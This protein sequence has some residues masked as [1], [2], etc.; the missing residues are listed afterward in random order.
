MGF[1]V[2]S[3]QLDDVRQRAWTIHVSDDVTR[4]VPKDAEASP[5]QLSKKDFDKSVRLMASITSALILQLNTASEKVMFRLN[6]AQFVAL[7]NALGRE[8]VTRMAVRSFTWIAIIAGALW[9]VG[10]IPVAAVPEE[11][12]EATTFSLFQM[13]LGIII[14]VAGIAGRF[15][16]HRFIVLIDA[17]WCVA[18]ACNGALDIINGVSSVW[19]GIASAALAGLALG[20]LKMYRLLGNI[21]REPDEPPADV[22][23]T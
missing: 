6:D 23:S 3:L 18:A 12:I 15:V 21:G 4:F 11:G 13:A 20:Q 16:A 8:Q 14:L 1:L 9:V 7:G 10:A 22:E 17:V 5:A 2:S 19:W